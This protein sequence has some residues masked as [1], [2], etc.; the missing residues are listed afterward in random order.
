MAGCR[1]LAS[2]YGLP[3]QTHLAESSVQRAAALARYGTSLTRHLDQLGVLG[4]RFS[5]AHAIWIDQAEVELIAARGGAIAHNP[6]SN[7]RL[8]NGIAD[9]RP[10]IQRGVPVAWCRC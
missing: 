9:M 6:G 1:D 4:P 7:L 10:A 8:G 3:L 5:A 2:E